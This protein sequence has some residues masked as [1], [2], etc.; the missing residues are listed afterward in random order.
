MRLILV[1]ILLHIFPFSSLFCAETAFTIVIASYNNAKWYKKN[2]DSIFKQT[3]NNYTVIYMDDVSPDDTGALVQEYIHECGM[4]H[5]VRLIKNEERRG[6]LYNTYHAIW[7]CDPQDIIIIL[8]GD[9]WL[10]DEH[11]LAYLNSVYADDNLWLTY[12]QFKYYPDNKKGYAQ[13]IPSKIIQSNGFRKFRWYSTHL[14]SFY[15][16][17]FQKIAKNDFLYENEFLPMSADIAYMMPMLEMAGIHSRFVSKILYVYNV[18]N[19]LN[20]SKKDLKKQRF[21]DKNIRSRNRYKPLE[22]L[23]SKGA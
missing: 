19:P 7:L 9:D 14:R 17:L 13:Q 6:A 22:C 8:D 3:Y 2:L 4:E 5:K 12:G 11:V 15:A 20:D 18:K 1:I 21:F 10:F 16:G 23:F